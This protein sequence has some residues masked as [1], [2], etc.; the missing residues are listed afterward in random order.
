MATA[1]DQVLTAQLNGASVGSP[2]GTTVGR[3]S[4]LLSGPMTMTIFGTPAA[5]T[6]KLQVSAD[7]TD[8]VNGNWVD[9]PS[10]GSI[11]APTIIQVNVGTGNM[12]RVVSTWTTIFWHCALIQRGV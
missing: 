11:T 7:S 8:G 3:Q 6:A 5:G 10:G 12:L 9:H 1:L 4:G 2:A